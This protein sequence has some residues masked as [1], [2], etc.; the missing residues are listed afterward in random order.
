MYDELSIDIFSVINMLS[1]TATAI[2]GLKVSF[3]NF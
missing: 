3:K 1:P 2:L